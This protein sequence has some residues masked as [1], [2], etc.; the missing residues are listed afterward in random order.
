[1]EKFLADVDRG[2]SGQRKSLSSKYF[3]D[4]QGSRIFQEIMEMPGYYLTRAE[5]EILTQ[6]AMRIGEAL[7]FRTRFNVVEL[8]A[9]D[10]FK[11]LEFL[12]RLQAG[13]MDF[14]YIPIDVSEEAV[15][16]LQERITAKGVKFEV[17]PQV[18]DYFEQI[19]GMDRSHPTLFLFLGANIG[20]YSHAECLELLRKLRHVMKPED[21]LLIGFDLQK[22]PLIIHQAY[23]DPEGITKRFNLNLLTRI[24]RELGG[25]FHL[26]QFDFY[27][28]YNPDNGELRSYLISL[29]P[30][31]VHIA[32]LGKDFS[33]GRHELI[34]TELSKKY[35]VLEISELAEEANFSLEMNFFDCQHYFVDSLW[36]ALPVEG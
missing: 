18:G 31:T 1:M 9:G 33:L 28:H 14:H 5:F 32:R 4:T 16:E 15:A 24:N 19:E 29:K 2:L 17:S 10:G 34:H 6:Q 3:Y 26:D 23:F 13:G 30:Q 35:D 25:N 20:N 27:C 21:R 36:R 11:T 7:K 8:G 12:E 22:S